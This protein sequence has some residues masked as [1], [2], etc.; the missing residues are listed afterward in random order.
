M[1]KDIDIKFSL[2]LQWFKPFSTSWGSSS[3]FHKQF[4][5]SMFM[6][7]GA[8]TER[9][10]VVGHILHFSLLIISYLVVLEK[11]AGPQGRLPPPTHTPHPHS[12]PPPSVILFWKGKDMSSGFESNLSWDGIHLTIY[13][14]L[15]LSWPHMWALLWIN[16]SHLKAHAQNMSEDLYPKPKYF[17]PHTMWNSLE[18]T[19]SDT[20]I[21]IQD[22]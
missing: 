18:V 22:I 6:C 1:T 13:R 17:S 10:V 12:P 3:H 21:Y 11:I 8:G 7:D 5:V 14:H 2:C 16:C 9:M 4:M 19:F 15:Y 20:T